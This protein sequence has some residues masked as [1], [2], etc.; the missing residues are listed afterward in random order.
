[1]T[2]T[3]TPITN[4]LADYIGNVT[5]RE[6]EPLRRLRETT[7]NHPMARWCCAPEQVQLLNLLTTLIG[8]RKTIEVGVFLGYSSGWVALALPP[9]GRLIACERSPEYAATARRTWQELGVENKIDFRLGPALETL[10]RLISDGQAGT[11]DMMFIDADK[12]NYANYYERAL[13]LLRK[14]GLIAVDNVLWS[15]RIIDP[16]VQDPDTQALR[17]FNEKVHHDQR[18]ALSLATIGDGL[19]LACKL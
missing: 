5:L 6:P 14:G 8:A 3:Y 13:V 11:F 16:A 19:T 7:Q 18:V 12:T 2:R 17:V 10:D 15:G 1:V 4:E 9:D